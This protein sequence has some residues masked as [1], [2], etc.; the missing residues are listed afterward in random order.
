MDTFVSQ[1]AILLCVPEVTIFDHGK[2]QES[3]NETRFKLRLGL[4][5][6]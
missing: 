3:V 6:F 2:S 4:R 5:N 1:S